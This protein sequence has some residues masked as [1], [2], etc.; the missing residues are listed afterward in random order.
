MSHISSL[1][2]SILLSTT[3]KECPIKCF[4]NLKKSIVKLIDVQ[5]FKIRDEKGKV[6]EILFL[7]NCR[8]LFYELSH[9]KML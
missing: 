1:P 8:N 4:V 3:K 7:S 6:L 5:T 2:V 9:R